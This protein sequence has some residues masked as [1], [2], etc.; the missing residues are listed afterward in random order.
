MHCVVFT[1]SVSVDLV[2]IRACYVWN[3]RHFHAYFMHASLN[4]LVTTLCS[5]W[6]VKSLMN[7]SFQ[8][9]IRG[10]QKWDTNT[11]WINLSL[12]R[13]HVHSMRRRVLFSLYYFCSHQ[14]SHKARQRFVFLVLRARN[15]LLLSLKMYSSYLQEEHGK[16]VKLIEIFYFL[17]DFIMHSR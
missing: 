7:S 16:Y 2:L 9:L 13:F 3:A 4:I 17:S 14:S 8:L 1:S 11:V 12:A 10:Q 6:G 15:R 5:E